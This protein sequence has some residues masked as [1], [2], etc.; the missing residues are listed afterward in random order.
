MSHEREHVT[1]EQA[2]AQRD[3]RKVVSQTVTLST[4][5]CPECG[6]VY[7]SGGVTRTVTANDNSDEI[8]NSMN[9]TGEE[10]AEL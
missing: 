6:R 9:N 5:V 4:A 7:V 2:R 1:N 3:D 10:N 8:A